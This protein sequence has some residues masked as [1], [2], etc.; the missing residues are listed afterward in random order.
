MSIIIFGT[1]FP[2]LINGSDLD[3]NFGLVLPVQRSVTLAQQVTILPADMILNLNLSQS[4]TWPLPRAA[5]RNGKPLIFV[6]AG[7]KFQAFPQTIT[8]FGTETIVNW[9]SPSSLVL[10]NN[11][12]VVAIHP[13]NDGTNNGWF[14]A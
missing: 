6:D 9:T 2:G 11:G 10:S 14:I 3:F 1:G 13:F 4:F 8:P 5:P 12:A 7:N